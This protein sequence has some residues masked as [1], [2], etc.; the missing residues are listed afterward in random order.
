MEEKTAAGRKALTVDVTMTAET[1]DELRVYD[2][3]ICQPKEGYRF[4][5]D[6]LLLC[7]FAEDASAGRVVDL[8][9]GCGIIPLIL[10]RKTVGASLVGVEFQEEMA[11]M[12]VRNVSLNGLDERIGIVS[13]D[14]LSLRGRFP[15]S[16][17][18]LVTANPPYRKPGSGRVSPKVGRDL[19]RHESSAGLADFLSTAKYL[20]KPSGSICFISHPSRLAEFVHCAGELRLSLLRLR[21]VH[22]SA[23]TPATMF[24]A[25]LAKGKKGGTLVLPPLLVHNEQGDYSQEVRSIL[26]E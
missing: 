21:M 13:D 12:A 7:G 17:F 14:I 9:T 16:S 10:A 15:V 1:I 19:A 26:G 25:Q 23:V 6:P 8:G 20:V 2:L 4:S 22:G 18:D 5:L 3:R 11:E 24:L